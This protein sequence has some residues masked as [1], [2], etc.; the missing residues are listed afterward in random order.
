MN[1][2]IQNPA[3]VLSKF[4]DFKILV[5]GDLM[6]DKF[7]KGSV[8]RISPE[9]P[10]PVVRIRDEKYVPGGAGNVA[11][12][13]AGLG[14]G[15]YVASVVGEDL[16]GRSLVDKLNAAGCSTDC[17]L[18]DAGR[19][20]TVKTR[21][22][23]E[24]QQVVRTDL[25]SDGEISDEKAKE[26]LLKIENIFDELDG[27]IISDYGK[28]MVTPVFIKGILKLAEKKSIPVVVDPQ[29]GH[30][31]EY[32]GVTALTPNTKEAREALKSEINSE[33]S[34]ARAGS[35]LLKRLDC[36]A[37]IITR[38]EEGMTIFER[39]EAY[40]HI[41]TAARE[42]YDVTGAGDTVAGVFTL[43]IVSGLDVYEA[44][45]LANY[46]AAVVVSKLG[47]AQ[48]SVEEIKKEMKGWGG[49]LL[50]L[51]PRGWLQAG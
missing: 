19:P 30:F 28:G 48:V 38:G 50:L 23:A 9:A 29:I 24:H 45:R 4:G 11:L 10:V 32:K 51:Y 34:L 36:R 2:N 1:Q 6:M 3:S 26:L 27:V 43:G 37:V 25:E 14:A 8:S 39:G 44:A 33:E 16:H 40:R 15:S 22:I 18:R 13:I 35:E 46:A 21:I 5:A 17:V 7:V 31:F 49:R 41:E 42:V 12:N 47:T 20:T